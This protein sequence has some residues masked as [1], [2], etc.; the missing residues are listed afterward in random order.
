MNRD[1]FSDERSLF[2]KKV[3][4][5]CRTETVTDVISDLIKLEILKEG[6]RSDRMT[7]LIEIYSV[8]GPTVFS[9]LVELMDGRLVQFPSPQQFKETVKTA[10]Y[11]YYKFLKG[12]DF[13][14]VDKFFNDDI[15]HIKLGVK[16]HSLHQWIQKQTALLKS[17]RKPSGL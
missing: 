7:P 10:V 2:Q 6:E 14:E 17:R 5:I 11:Y 3:N 9:E 13:K 1:I 12:S 8:L 15:N 4:D 16:T